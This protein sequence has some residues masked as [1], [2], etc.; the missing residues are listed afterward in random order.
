MYACISAKVGDGPPTPAVFGG[1]QN[2]DKLGIAV[3]IAAESDLF[4]G[5]V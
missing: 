4:D 3:D 5:V 2:V 1:K